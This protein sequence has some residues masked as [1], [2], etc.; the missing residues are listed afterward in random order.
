[1]YRA[2]S[3]I[4]YV[5]GDFIVK[6]KFFTRQVCTKLADSIEMGE[7]DGKNFCNDA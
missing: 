3:C 7:I 5:R 2:K 4:L 1:M 6:N